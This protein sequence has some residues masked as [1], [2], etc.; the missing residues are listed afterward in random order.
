MRGIYFS[1]KNDTEGFRL[2][3]NPATVN[4]KNAG[5]GESFKI[6]K[7]GSVNVPKDVELKEFDIESFFP[8]QPYHFLE[9]DF[10]EPTFYIEKLEK[11]M[12][13]KEPVRYIYVD[14]SFAINELVTIESFE[15]DE[16]FG[17]ADVNYTLALKKYV[18]FAPKKLKVAKPKPPET[19]TAQTTQKPAQKPAVKKETPPPQNKKT[20]PQTYSLVKGDSLW[21]VAQKYTG[22]GNNYPELAKLNGIKPSQYRKLPIGLKLKIPPS[23]TK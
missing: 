6:A 10:R 17:T 3:V 23:W 22:N 18:P 4:V 1:V 7:L 12:A 8:A 15:Y 19:Q 9:T 20:V 5:D 14:G 21:K 16:S 11:W 2:P 13:D